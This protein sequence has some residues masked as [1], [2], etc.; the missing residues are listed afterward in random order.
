MKTTQTNEK[1][2][3]Q[4]TIN[5]GATTIYKVFN[6]QG[7]LCKVIY[8]GNEYNGKLLNTSPTTHLHFNG[9]DVL[10]PAT[11]TTEN[12]EQIYTKTTQYNGATN[13]E[14]FKEILSLLQNKTFTFDKST[15]AKATTRNTTKANIIDFIN[16]NE[17]LKIEYTNLNFEYEQAKARFEIAKTHF[18]SFINECKQKATQQQAENTVTQLLKSGLITNEQLQAIAQAQ[19]QGGIK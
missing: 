14:K 5:N 7:N 6:I 4:N 12:N 2:Q 3:A 10:L 16:A 11:I 15:Q 1:V 19:K 17:Q 18:D 9:L 13:Q 8:N